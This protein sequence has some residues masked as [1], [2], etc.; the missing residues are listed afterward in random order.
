MQV[1]NRYWTSS[2]LFLIVLLVIFGDRNA[3]TF[4]AEGPAR[5]EVVIRN[6]AYEV[7]GKPLTPGVPAM[8][9]LRNVDQV[10]HGFTSLFLQEVDVRVE[11]GGSATLGKGIRGVHIAPGAEM[12]IL[13]I[14]PRPGK[15][16]FICDLH[17]QMKGEVLLLSIGAV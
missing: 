5:V 15:F 17:P 16:T 3:V 9:V 14:P 13:F 7:Q 6:S 10:E 1:R 2:T 8:I 12:R 11:S 4:P